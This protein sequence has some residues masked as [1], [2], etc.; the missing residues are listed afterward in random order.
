M[1]E[2]HK[3]I[4]Q[5]ICNSYIL[6]SKYLLN[7]GLEENKLRLLV[8]N[9]IERS[10]FNIKIRKAVMKIYNLKEEELVICNHRREKGKFTAILVLKSNFSKDI[11][12]DELIKVFSEDEELKTL[13]RVDK[14]LFMPKIKLSKS[15][16]FPKEDNKK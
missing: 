13:E 14:E 15:M 7:F 1:S 12:K 2:Y 9:P 11:T 3:N 16:L 4:I 8:K 6:K 5:S 10:N